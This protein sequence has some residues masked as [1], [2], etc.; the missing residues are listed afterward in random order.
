MRIDII[1]LFPEYF[2]G[3]LGCGIVRVAQS[4]GQLQTTVVNPRDFT[5]DPHR[6]ADD[7]PFG[8][9]PGMVL[10]PEPIHRALA[11]VRSQVAHVVMM[12][13]RG[14]TFDQSIAEQFSRMEHL[15]LICGRYKGVDERI[16]LECD[17]EVS[18]GDFVLSGG[19]AAATSV[20]EAVARLLPGAVGDTESV[21][22]DSFT[23]GLL[24]C[25]YYTRPATFDGMSVPEQV[26]AGDHSAVAAWR[27]RQSISATARRRPQLLRNAVLTST[28]RDALC[29]EIQ[30]ES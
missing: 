30:K 17:D 28:E 24:D 11:S 16:R 2:D 8:G 29:L 10:K 7:Y 21:D 3:P 18:L 9:G 22:T 15:I 23:S 1:S 27:R 19:E 25:P 14:R 5:R 20:T 13:P 4:R 6:T 26:L 12:S